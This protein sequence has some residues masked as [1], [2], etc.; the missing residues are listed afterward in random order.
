MNGKY[1]W[2]NFHDPFSD[3]L[4]ELWTLWTYDSVEIFI[5]LLTDRFLIF[6][7]IFTLK[8]KSEK[9]LLLPTF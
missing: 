1:G 6:E 7:P 3:V 8:V 2:K 5:R 4:L 9:K